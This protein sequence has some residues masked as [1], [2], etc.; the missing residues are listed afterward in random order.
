[1]PVIN[2]IHLRPAQ[3]LLLV[4]MQN[5]MILVAHYRIGG[6]IDGKI[7]VS[8]SN[9]SSIHCLRSSKFYPVS[10]SSPHKKV[11]RTNA[12]H[13]DNRGWYQATPKSS[14]VLA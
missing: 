10:A 7:L 8:S 2:D 4:D 1:M 9:R 5:Y 14:L 13:N 11:R 3:C 12:K 6:N